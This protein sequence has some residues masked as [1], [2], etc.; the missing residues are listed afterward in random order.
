MTT[1]TDN[2]DNHL[3][4]SHNTLRKTFLRVDFPVEES[5]PETILEPKEIHRIPFSFVVPSHIP[6]QM[7][8]HTCA[9]CQVHEEHLQLLPSLGKI[10]QYFENTHDMS[11]SEAEITYSIKFSVV[12]KMSNAE[13]PKILKETTYPI[14]IL[15]R[16]SEMAPLLLA[17]E[18]RYYKIRKEKCLKKGI[19]RSEVG[20]L[21]LSTFQPLGIELCRG[22][23]PQNS[24][25]AS[26]TVRINLRFD[27]ARE[28]ELPP[29]MVSSEIKL[30]AMTF[31]GMEPWF[32]FPDHS[33]PS[34][35]G[36]RQTYWSETISLHLEDCFINWRKQ[37]K[38]EGSDLAL[39]YTASVDIS[40]ALPDTLA[41]P[42]T[43]H[44]CFISRA[45]ALKT[46]L[47]YQD[48]SKWR[49]SASAS[50]TVP[51]Q[52]YVS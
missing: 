14:Y 6:A 38:A 15:P 44:S 35:W 13:W 39:F 19:L 33:G 36:S 17:P 46:I 43:F 16:R 34:A 49:G 28:K 24:I 25:E 37:A 5:V 18:S 4:V 1:E 23:Q 10:S 41:Y 8:H 20:T 22:P 26:T 47:S 27:P 40:I 48:H 21:V 50:L 2:L 32:S 31:F 12:E 7:C 52:I 30:K 42:P 9:N 51:V 3:P 45:Y 29:H 11:P